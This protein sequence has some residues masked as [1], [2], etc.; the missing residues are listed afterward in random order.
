MA[1][2]YIL[3]IFS[4]AILF[5]RAQDGRAQNGGADPAAVSKNAPVVLL[6]RVGE[7][8]AAQEMESRFATDLGLY[9]DGF[10]I[11]ESQSPAAAFVDASLSRQIALIKPMM[12]EKNAVAAMWLNQVS[13]EVLLLQVVVLDTGRALVRL[14]E[15][16]LKEG[17]EEE[18]AVTAAELLG[19][20]YLFEH[21]KSIKSTPI[22]KLVET[23]RRQAGVQ[24]SLPSKWRLFVAA[25][26]LS[27][28]ADSVGPMLS[29][30]GSLGFD[31][32]LPKEFFFA[33]ELRGLAGPFGREGDST[34][35]GFEIHANVEVFFGPTLKKVRFGPT[36]T[37]FGG[38]SN[39][40][41]ERQGFPRG[42]FAQWIFSGG[43]GLQLR[44][45]VL[46]KC[47]IKIA[48]G[49]SATPTRM[50]IRLRSTDET[51]YRRGILSGWLSLGVLLF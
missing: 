42:D 35:G 22:R 3:F 30:G 41:V 8:L 9:I 36:V 25:F 38:P 10:S 27:G 4:F 43:V 51:I 15:H 26:G 7:N 19:T 29:I 39:V 50:E 17:S 32:T 13:T 33:A 2:R 47:S 28:F 16:S 37:L 34:F 49:I 45:P 24:A 23:T 12:V 20:A 14:F 18:L 11:Q 1:F 6:I 44:V 40:S 31:R 48:S 21:E 46:K 5:F